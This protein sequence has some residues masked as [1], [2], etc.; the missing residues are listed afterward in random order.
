M[1]SHVLVHLGHVH[2]VDEQDQVLA[3]R[4]TV[5]TLAPSLNVVFDGS[6]Q[7]KRCCAGTE[8]DIQLGPG[9]SAVK[10]LLPAVQNYS[11]H[12]SMQKDSFEL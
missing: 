10:K 8:I 9:I 3:R 11:N 12:T 2:V 5:N 6:L 4:G 7:I 1:L